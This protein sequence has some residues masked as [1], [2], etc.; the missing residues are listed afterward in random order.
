MNWSRKWLVDF[1]AGKTQFVSLGQSNNTDAIDMKMH[2]SVLE[3]NHLLRCWGWLSPPNWIRALTLSL[4]VKLFPKKLELDSLYEVSFSC[5]CSLSLSIY[6]T[7]MHAR[8]TVVTSGL[9]LLVATWNC[10]ISYKNGYAGLLALQL[11]PLLNPWLI[12]EI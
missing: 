7:T 10:W 12:I 8:D 1:N 9:V 6:H 4:L 3:E 11:T 2:G 5:G